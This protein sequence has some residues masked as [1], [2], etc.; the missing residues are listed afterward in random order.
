LGGARTDAPPGGF[1]ATISA[2]AMSSQHGPVRWRGSMAATLF[3]EKK[4]AFLLAFMKNT[5]FA[6]NYFGKFIDL[7]QKITP[8]IESLN[9]K[10]LNFKS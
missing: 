4:Q 1:H 5:I 2:A 9:L 7:P 10:S 6:E 8:C 3:Y